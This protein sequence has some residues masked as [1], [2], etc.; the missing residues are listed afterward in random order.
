[1]SLFVPSG[2]EI[3]VC[4]SGCVEKIAYLI[5]GVLMLLV[6]AMPQC[7]LFGNSIVYLVLVLA[8]F[9]S[10]VLAAEPKRLPKGCPVRPFTSQRGKQRTY[11]RKGTK[12]R[13]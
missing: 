5:L 13:R 10:L 6:V 11:L 8:V 3:S 4:G 1:M 2:L 9:V 7:C 12:M